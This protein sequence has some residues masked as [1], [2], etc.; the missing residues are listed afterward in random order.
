MEP[1]RDGVPAQWMRGVP[2][3][4]SRTT[5]VGPATATRCYLQE[6]DRRASPCPFRELSPAVSAFDYRLRVGQARSVG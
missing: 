3:Q 5:V 1:S 2:K 6:A 4:A